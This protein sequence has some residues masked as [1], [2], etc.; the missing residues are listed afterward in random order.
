MHQIFLKKVFCYLIIFQVQFIIFNNYRYIRYPIHV[1]KILFNKVY[2]YT[3]A[4]FLKLSIYRK[5]EQSNRQIGLL[6]STE[7]LARQKISK[8]LHEYRRSTFRNRK[9][10]FMFSY[11]LIHFSILLI[12]FSNLLIHF[13]TLLNCFSNLLNCFSNLLIRISKLLNFWRHLLKKYYFKS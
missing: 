4:T 11:L 10:P 1:S 5:I 9:E 13:S 3:H 12:H 8:K 2:A 6:D 7:K